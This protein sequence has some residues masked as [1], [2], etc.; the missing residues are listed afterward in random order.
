MFPRIHAVKLTAALIALS[1]FAPLVIAQSYPAKS[2]RIVV[3]Y[4]PG[5]GVDITTRLFTPKLTERLGQQFVVDNRAGAGGNVGAEYVAHG[6]PDGYLLLMAP[7]SI[8]ISQSL[9][10]NLRYDLKRDFDAIAMIGS[11]P[12]VLVMHP[13]APARTA[14]ELIALAKSHPK[15]LSY[16]SSG[17]GSASHLVAEMFNL[18][19]GIN[20]LHIP[21]KGT[22]P[23]LTDV[24]AGFVSLTFANTLSGL[25]L[26]NAGRLRA[27][28]ITSSK[29]SSTAPGLPTLAESGLP[30]FE[31]VTWFS[32]LAPKGTPRD[33]ITR[34]N[35]ALAEIG[36]SQDTRDRLGEQGAE[37]LGGTPEQVTSFIAAETVKWAKVVAA[38]GARA[39]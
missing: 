39:E 34:L 2:V 38:S 13:S 1:A 20:V 36:Q 21:Y 9:Y 30:G 5:A 19:A 3:P 12:F 26:V 27:L 10:K 35:S 7:A 15:Q 6:A 14:R 22:V 25:P 28:G 32:L 4:P 29:R 11:A 16:A 17:S 8:A 24:I 23:A 33:I 31:G 37:S 18:Q